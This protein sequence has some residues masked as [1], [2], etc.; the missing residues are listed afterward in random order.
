MLHGREG[1][2]DRRI[3]AAGA[4]MP[5]PEIA[6][7]EDQV[8]VVALMTTSAWKD[9]LLAIAP[10]GPEYAYSTGRDVPD[11]PPPPILWGQLISSVGLKREENRLY[12]NL[13]GTRVLAPVSTVGFQGDS[14]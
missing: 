10:P 12:G 11:G 1:F 14:N 2:C 5:L 13:R 9:I 8:D 3:V 4:G 6:V 7:A